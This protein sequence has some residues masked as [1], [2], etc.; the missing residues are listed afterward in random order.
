MKEFTETESNSQSISQAALDLG[1]AAKKCERNALGAMNS[2]SI[3]H[4]EDSTQQCKAWNET[5]RN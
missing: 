4:T 5:K 2:E 3:H 1:S